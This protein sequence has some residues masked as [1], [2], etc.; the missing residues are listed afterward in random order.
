MKISEEQLLDLIEKAVDA[1]IKHNATLIQDAFKRDILE[2][3]GDIQTLQIDMLLS[4]IT[5]STEI[6]VKTT[7]SLLEKL[8]LV[9]VDRQTES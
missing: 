8:G 3:D 5:L 9:D 4:C 6:S 2:S 7:L 1:N